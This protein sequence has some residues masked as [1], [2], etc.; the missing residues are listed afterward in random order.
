MISLEKL[1]INYEKIN[2]LYNEVDIKKLSIS[3]IKDFSF[4]IKKNK[5]NLLE[6]KNKIENII[7]YREKFFSNS[8]DV[9]FEFI[10]EISEA[11]FIKGF[12]KNFS[13]KEKNMYIFYSPSKTMLYLENF[14]L[15]ESEKKEIED[16]VSKDLDISVEYAIKYLKGRFFKVE[17]LL[18]KTNN[19]KLINSYTSEVIKN[20]WPEYEK[21]CLEKNNLNSLLNYVI[22]IKNFLTDEDLSEFKK[23]FIES[24]DDNLQTIYLV[25][26]ENKNYEYFI[27]DLVKLYYYY[28]IIKDDYSKTNDEIEKVEEIIFQ[29]PELTLHYLRDRSITIGSVY[30]KGLETISKNDYWLYVLIFINRKFH[31]FFGFN[32]SI[33]NNIKNEKYKEEILRMLKSDVKVKI[34]TPEEAG[35]KT[36]LDFKNLFR[37]L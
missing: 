32:N 5:K 14:E 26:I 3:N 34:I 19:K 1:I 11:L 18:I 27:N 33:I 28:L 8:K 6:N 31:K 36:L 35:E 9:F 24:N 21:Y 17:P 25:K 4:I 20:R 13:N 15:K 23:I 2:I 12:W 37:Q 7:E 10:G 29:Y 16:S 22:N 30:D